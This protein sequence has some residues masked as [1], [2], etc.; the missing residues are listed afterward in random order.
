MDLSTLRLVNHLS[1][2]EIL[3]AFSLSPSFRFASLISKS[4]FLPLSTALSL[5][6]M[7]TVGV[8]GKMLGRTLTERR[9]WL[10]DKR[11]LESL[12]PLV[13]GS[14]PDLVALFLRLIDF[15]FFMAIWYA[16]S[17]IGGVTPSLEEAAVD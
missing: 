10:L 4:G 3:V 1:F 2:E 13:T 6:R 14:I 11:A 17:V 9:A 8:I 12:W 15:F 16:S 5:T 7:R